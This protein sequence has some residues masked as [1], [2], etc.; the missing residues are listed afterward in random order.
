MSKDQ[1]SR[2]TAVTVLAPGLSVPRGWPSERVPATPVIDR[3]LRR[4]SRCDLVGAGSD[5]AGGSLTTRLLR[6][7][8]ATA[9]G[10]FAR[11][12]DDPSWGRQ[13]C[14]AQA[15]PVHLRPDRD[16]LRLFDARHLG[17][18][19]EEAD[20]LV[21]EL[22]EH[23]AGEAMRLVA[24]TASRWYLELP[25]PSLLDALP[26][27]RVAGRSVKHLSPQGSDARRWAAIMTEVQMLLFGSAVN[28]ARQASARP[29]VNGIWISG[30]GTWRPLENAQGW[31]R[32]CSGRAL[33]RGLAEAAG[34]QLTQAD[35]EMTQPGTLAVADELAEAMLD[36][37]PER[38]ARAASRLDARLAGALAALRSGE[39]GLVELDLC[40]GRR[41][42]A[43]RA[44]LRRFWR[45][46]SGLSQLEAL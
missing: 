27:D 34:V 29:A 36:A 22:N 39:L 31:T 38:W 5:L 23:L 44:D 28:Q 41:W 16:Q 25:E 2:K 6:L 26:L 40:D 24:P 46:G 45:R 11:A 4:G 37:D 21:A 19:Q 9:S 20:A 43:R 3:F 30:A 15:D 32:L 35:V 42:C 12:A 1:W 10:P 13:G 14:V 17:L 8:G 7:F 33:A 18:A